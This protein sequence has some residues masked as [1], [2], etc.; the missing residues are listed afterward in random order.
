M[1]CRI[2]TA[3]DQAIETKITSK[4]KPESTSTTKILNNDSE[5]KK[6]VNDITSF[7]DDPTNNEHNNICLDLY[8]CLATFRYPYVLHATAPS[9]SYMCLMLTVY[10]ISK[11]L[12]FIILFW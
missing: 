11:L 4:L 9:Y 1:H 8:W 3:L 5:K 6:N 10:P 7:I 2:A 12:L